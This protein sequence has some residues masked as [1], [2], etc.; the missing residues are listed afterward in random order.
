MTR[1]FFRYGSKELQQ[2]AILADR[3]PR[4]LNEF[5]AQS[6]ISAVSNRAASGSLSGGALGG[7]QSQKGRQL[8]NVFDLAPVPDTGKHLA[9]HD[10]ADT[11]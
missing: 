6:W 7:H 1:M 2:L 4:S 5:A 8:T 9:G 11:S 3:R 10:P